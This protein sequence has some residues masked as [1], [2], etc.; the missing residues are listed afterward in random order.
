MP[1]GHGLCDDCLR[2]YDTLRPALDYQYQKLSG[3]FNSEKRKIAAAGKGYGLS[4]TEENPPTL[5]E[6]LED[7]TVLCGSPETVCTQIQNLRDALGVG[8][9]SMH[10]QVGNMSFEHALHSMTQ[11]AQGIR[12]VFPSNAETPSREPSR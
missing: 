6:R 3:T 4:P 1:V 2:P 7:Q 8:V 5:D 10:F 9:V 12:P 11:F